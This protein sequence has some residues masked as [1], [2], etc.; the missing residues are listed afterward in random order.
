[1]YDSSDVS[2]EIIISKHCDTVLLVS[3]IQITMLE[4]M[5]HNKIAQFNLGKKHPYYHLTSKAT[6]LD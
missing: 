5:V 4:I 1:M 2:I 3:F 6:F